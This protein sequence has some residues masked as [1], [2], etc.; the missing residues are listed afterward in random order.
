MVSRPGKLTGDYT[1]YQPVS[2][3][4]SFGISTATITNIATGN[5]PHYFLQ[6]TGLIESDSASASLI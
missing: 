6:I 3:N 1:M 2:Q 4:Y 5:L